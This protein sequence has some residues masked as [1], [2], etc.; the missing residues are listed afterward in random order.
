ML[1]PPG[2]AVALEEA[3]RKLLADSDL[4]ARLGAAAAAFVHAELS[5]DASALRMG[6]IYRNA[7]SRPG[8]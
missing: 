2:D 1:F 5:L 3:L 4:R 7:M 6:E 8:R